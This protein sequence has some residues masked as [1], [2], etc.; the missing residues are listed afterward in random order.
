MALLSKITLPNGQS[1][2]IRDNAAG[3]YL[4]TTTTD[5]TAS[6]APTTVSIGG[7]EVTVRDQDIVLYGGLLYIALKPSTAVTW[8][9][10]TH[11]A[12]EA[13]VTDV[14]V[15]GTT[16]ITGTVANLNTTGETSGTGATTPYDAS[17]NPVA[18]KEYVD[19]NDT[20]KGVSI[21]STALTADSNKVVD[22]AT[23]G[24]Y[25]GDSTSGTYNP[26]ATKY[27]DYKA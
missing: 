9:A 11:A 4:G 17:E 19:S 18:T 21:D 24:N 16:I 2:D 12:P 3:H 1:Y 5:V 15:D 23:T 14:Q 22:V 25:D 6:T 10:L 7:T 13:D 8:Q 27:Y 26:L 20:I